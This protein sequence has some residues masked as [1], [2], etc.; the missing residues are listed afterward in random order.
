MYFCVFVAVDK[1]AT[2]VRLLLSLFFSLL[3]IA[4]VAGQRLLCS[5]RCF[6]LARE[7]N[8][9]YHVP[10][11]PF[12][13]LTKKEV[14]VRQDTCLEEDGKNL[15]IILTDRCRNVYTTDSSVRCALPRACFC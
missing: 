10:G 13:F 2:F 8:R 3:W 1:A 4:L 9:S 11:E 12:R 15:C 7:P 6:V 14:L 5:F